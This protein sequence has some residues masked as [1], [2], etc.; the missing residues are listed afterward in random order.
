[1]ASLMPDRADDLVDR[2]REKPEKV[3]FPH[4]VV[5]QALTYIIVLPDEIV[6]CFWQ[7]VNANW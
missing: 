4:L 3:L 1:M 6:L 5:L 7:F 2:I